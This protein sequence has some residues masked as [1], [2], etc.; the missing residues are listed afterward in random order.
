MCECGLP[1]E[2]Y[3]V[4]G[5]PSNLG[6]AGPFA[7]QDDGLTLALADMKVKAI[8]GPEQVMETSRFQDLAT[9]PK[10][11]V[12]VKKV[13]LSYVPPSSIIYEARAFQDG[14]RKYGPYNWRKNKVVA[15]IY[16]DA[17]LR[18]L[19]AFQ[20]GESD[21]ADSK[22]PHLGHAKACIGILIDALET[23]NLVD[24]RPIPGPASAILER[25][26]EK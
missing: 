4:E 7:Q 18:H 21:A 13:P 17:A 20:D 9:N 24:D 11:L 26:K 2:E 22:V 5:R 12:G 1:H 16:F 23:G 15:S 10:D 3:F 6:A 19:L 8:L 25:W 14:A